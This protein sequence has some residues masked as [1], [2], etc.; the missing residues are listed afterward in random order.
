MEVTTK[1]GP[2][3]VVAVAFLWL[4]HGSLHAQRLPP[5]AA[6]TPSEALDDAV[7]KAEALEEAG[8]REQAAV[9]WREALEL[10]EAELEPD[11]PRLGTILVRLGVLDAALGR[12]AEA[13]RQFERTVA[14]LEAAV[15]PEDPSLATILDF[16]GSLY[17][18]ESRY[19][20]AE[21]LF[22][23]IVKMREQAAGPD[24]PD[25]ATS[26]ETL[27]GL[28]NS[29]GRHLEAEP[30]C[31]RALAIFENAY[32]PD[33]PQVAETLQCLGDSYAGQSRHG[34]AQL[35]FERALAILERSSGPDHPDVAEALN[36]LGGS[37][38]GQGRYAEAQSL[39]ER[40]LAI[41]EKELGTDAPAVARTLN[42]L[43]EAYQ[44][45]GR[46]ADAEP[47]HQRALTI[48]ETA[49]G[50]AHHQVAA[51]LQRLGDLYATLGRYAEAEPLFRRALKIA[52]K[53]LGPR[54]REVA[55]SLNSLSFLY[56]NQGRYTEAEPLLRRALEIE[57]QTLGSEHPDF[58][59][60]LM[61]LGG[62][63]SKQGRLAEARPLYERAHAISEK[64]LPPEH[65]N[66][67][68]SHSN[69]AL[70]HKSQGRLAEAEVL[71]RRALEIAEKVFRP[72]H[73]IVGLILHTLA[74]VLH[75]QGR[76]AEAEPLYGRS[77]AILEAALGPR[78]PAV[79]WSSSSQALLSAE[80]GRDRE[81]LARIR[82][83]SAIFQSRT[84]RL[85]ASRGSDPLAEQLSVRSVFGHHVNLCL[86]AIEPDSEDGEELLLEAFEATQLAHATVIDSAV[87]RMAVRFATGDD[88]LGRVVRARQDAVDRWRAQDKRLIDAV[89]Q[90]AE[91][92]DPAVEARLR[93]GIE[94]LDARVADLD[95][96]LAREFPE[97]AELAVPKPA[98]LVEIQDLLGPGEALLVY[99][100]REQGGYLWVV[101][102][103]T[104]SAVSLDIDERDL[105]RA[106]GSLRWGLEQ[107]GVS[108][109][110]RLR[111]YR[112]EEAWALYEKIFAPVEPWLE[113]VE[114]L[115]IVADGAL[116]SLPL[117]VLVTEEPERVRQRLAAYR[118][119]AWLARRYAVT[120]L[121]SVA[122][123]RAL[124]RLAR[125]ARSRRPFVGFGAPVLEGAAGFD[126]GVPP[127]QLFTRGPVA[128]V[129]AVRQLS[130]LP[131]TADELFALAAARGA[132]RAS[133]FVGERATEARV[134]SMSLVDYRVL[135]FA[136][137]GLVAGELEGLAEPSLVLT[138]PPEGTAA[139]DGLLTASEIAELE[140]DAD[141]VILSACNTAT[142]EAAGAEGLSG[143]AKAFFYAGARAL[144]V[145]H[146]SVESTAAVALTTGMFAEL[147]TEPGIGR[148]EALR[149]SMLALMANEEHDHFAHPM[150]WAPFTVVGEGGGRP[151][152]EEPGDDLPVAQ[153]EG[154][155]ALDVDPA[156]PLR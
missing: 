90:P 108:R 131:D 155:P 133:V 143:L 129:E 91:K 93:A 86:K 63:Y 57:E 112:V 52:E 19:D 125:P 96:R 24:H 121:P 141:W 50:P 16:L 5:R 17:A 84:R 123:L 67:A 114:H 37:H 47:L 42:H 134:R 72:E 14:I 127:A 149:R 78:H 20:E 100:V 43:G 46:F 79:A 27:A 82:R 106:V 138:P 135:A 53:T 10:L 118:D 38:G 65:P 32:G 102:P 56:Y 35:L 70:L 115:F 80:R 68:L 137:H 74:V 8:R 128:D 98:P 23:R 154:D 22:R 94:A 30:L 107:P 151:S 34:E 21:E 76:Y 69:L 103:D 99:L 55:T 120:T 147:S 105:G 15:G 59:A 109:V 62:L 122:S 124:R 77:L 130:A 146:W 150:F 104:V 110:E 139:D 92:R 152:E 48:F 144:L 2:R 39:F 4:S 119:V 95:E 136:T 71:S 148:S 145:S 85:A 142:A 117:G 88:R 111:R 116:Q 31:E 126:R 54:H 40:A 26:L 101:R 45:Q 11:H 51:T 18:A 13:V 156:L 153:L 33:H 89:S 113:G 140:L 12:H 3:I 28:H 44:R 81:A 29:R 75:D 64:A 83:A 61:A 60:T 66:L 58:A 41:F 49:Y 1:R 7:R 25:Y 132:E 97:Y 73:R 87:A 9:A 6:P 36:R